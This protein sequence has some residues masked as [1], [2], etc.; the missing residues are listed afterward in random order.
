[1]KGSPHS[2]LAAGGSAGRAQELCP[3]QFSQVQDIIPLKIT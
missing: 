2:T 1:M 3:C